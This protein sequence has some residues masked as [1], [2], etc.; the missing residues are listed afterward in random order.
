MKIIDYISSL[1]NSVLSPIMLTVL[2]FGSV[3][4]LCILKFFPFTHPKKIFSS[5]FEKKQTGSS[6]PLKALAV[7]LAGTLGVGN[8]AG[9][10]FAISSGGAGAVFWLCLS[11]LLLSIVKYAEVTLAVKTRIY[12]NGEYLGG[13]MYYI[14]SPFI[15][16]LFAVLCIF[17][18]FT[19]GTLLQS[20]SAAESL[21]CTFKISPYVSGAILAL[22]CFIVIKKGLRGVSNFCSVVIPF[23][24][25]IYL[26][27]CLY[28]IISSFS[29]LPRIFK[30]ICSDAFSLKSAVCGTGASVISKSIR[31]G[32]S[33]GLIT[34]ESGCG[35]APIAHACSETDSP[36]S[37]G[38]LGIFEVIA[39]TVLCLAS[40]LV[41]LLSGCSYENSYGMTLVL[42]AFEKYMGKTASFIISPQIVLFALASIVGWSFYGLRSIS[43]ISKRKRWQKI[44]CIFIALF[45]FMGALIT[46]DFILLFSDILI[47][48]MIIINMVTLIKKSSVIAKETDDFFKKSK[49]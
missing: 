5:L 44:Y 6:H 16:C 37:Q 13:P 28:I 42:S 33:R 39:D 43:F 8:I 24:C 29:A 48:F 9:V 25:A 7:A 11:S 15:G 40:A 4:F 10:A 21:L 49:S 34:N 20:S 22:I 17:C 41:I 12:S 45:A 18:S 46:N 36:V 35:T 31:A 27:M 19:L 32:V 3:Y 47:F 2:A 23:M 14:K 1:Y 38:F 26:L 30:T